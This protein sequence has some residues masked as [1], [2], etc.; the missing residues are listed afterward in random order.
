MP[1]VRSR[2][3]HCIQRKDPP[4]ASLA[5]LSDPPNQYVRLTQ[6]PAASRGAGLPQAGRV[7]IWGSCS[8]KGSL[9]GPTL[10][11]PRSELP[12]LSLLSTP[13]PAPIKA[14][15]LPR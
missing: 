9:A 13:P 12:D 6:D 7:H 3:G 2:W 15:T 11:W 14:P 5:T 8:S 4:K 1:W 10:L